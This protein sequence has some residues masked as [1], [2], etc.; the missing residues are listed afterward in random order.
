MALTITPKLRL[1]RISGPHL[2]A[3]HTNALKLYRTERLLSSIFTIVAKNNKKFLQ[4]Q[5]SKFK[6]QN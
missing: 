1:W 5:K 4:M 3:F 2:H 6:M